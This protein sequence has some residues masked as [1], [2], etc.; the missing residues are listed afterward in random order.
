MNGISAA[1][2]SDAFGLNLMQLLVA[3]QPGKNLFVSPLSVFLAL[4]MTVNGA[5]P[6]TRKALQ[7]ALH[8]PDDLAQSNA[9]CRELLTVL[10]QP[11][12]DVTLELANALWAITPHRFASD[13]QA[14]IQAAFGTE[15]QQVALQNAAS[16][17]NAWAEDKTHRRVKNVVRPADFDH[18][19]VFALSNATYFKGIWTNK[20][21]PAQTQALPFQRQDGTTRQAKMMHATL[22]LAQAHTP[23]FLAIRLPYSTGRFQM[24]A[25]LPAFGQTPESILPKLTA[26]KSQ[27]RSAMRTAQTE[28]YFP[29]LN[30]DL[31]RLELRRVMET[32]GM[33]GTNN[34][35]PLGK[36]ERGP[37]YIARIFHKTRLE[38]D[39]AGTRAAATT[40]VIIKSRGGSGPRPIVF[41]RP[42][43]LCLADEKSH[44]ILFTGIVHDPV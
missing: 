9:A 31:P 15:L 38:L 33:L 21:D 5:V 44:T 1:Q 24:Y 7:A 2:A 4:A 39:E 22:P 43:V 40:V 37:L 20:F 29:K 14:R 19:V 32:R 34:V 8:L 25:F 42:F 27:Q 28:L 18:N 3:D 35:T 36:S 41:N 30:L 17:I 12:P 23:E 11:E 6:E 16:K 10:T 13:V 26:F